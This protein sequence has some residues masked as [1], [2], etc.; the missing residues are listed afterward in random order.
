MERQFIDVP[1]GRVAYQ[2]VGDGPR[3]VVWVHGLP[4]DSDSWA[5]QRRHFAPLA[6]NV[7]PDLRGYGHSDKLPADCTD[8]TQQYVDDLHA[9]T[10]TLDVEDIVL[11]GFASAGHVALRYAAQH[12]QRVSDLVVINASPRFRRG[13]DWPWGFTDEGI[14]HFTDAARDGGIE[15]L[16][17]AV[18]EPSLVFRDVDAEEAGRLVE[19]FRPMS[20]HAGVAT[21]L[22]FFDGIS[23]DDDRALLPLIRARVLVVAATIGQ[24][25]PS[26][27]GL[28]LRTHVPGARLVEIPGADHFVFAT[29]PALINQLIEQV[30]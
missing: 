6:Q 5:H 18:L 23:R 20:L 4:L 8:V 16:T 29:R 17:D 19:W 24:E 22:G 3:T 11:V 27:V 25:V 15:A 1:G 14:A 10:A 21:L 12:P 30:L 9:L 28:Y 2:V 13:P 7:F 26:D